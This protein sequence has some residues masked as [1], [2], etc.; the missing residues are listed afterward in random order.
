[1]ARINPITPIV[2]IFRYAF[3]GAG[4][5]SWGTLAYSFLMMIVVF[6]V[7]VLLFNRVEQTFM[8]TV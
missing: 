3:L 2:E 6:F 5:V 7:G 8:D 4:T 1:V